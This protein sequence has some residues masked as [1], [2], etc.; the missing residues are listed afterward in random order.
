MIDMMYLKLLESI[1]CVP[2]LMAEHYQ[3]GQSAISTGRTA[4]AAQILNQSNK[5]EIRRYGRSV[6]MYRLPIRS[7]CTSLSLLVD[8]QVGRTTQ[9]YRGPPFEPPPP[10]P[11]ITSTSLIFHFRLYTNR[12]PSRHVLYRGRLDT[13]REIHDCPLYFVTFVNCGTHSAFRETNCVWG[14][15]SS[16]T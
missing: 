5:K 2:L 12:G 11:L 4:Q 10:T 3:G 16:M 7:I 13:S 14:E 15:I 9:F 6:Y 8:C 1:I